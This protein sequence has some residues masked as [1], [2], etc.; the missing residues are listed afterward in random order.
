MEIITIQKFIH[1]SPRKVRLV[2][3]MVRKMEPLKALEVLHFTQKYAARDLSKA[4]E[5]A[6]A[7][8]KQ[9]GLTDGEY[10]FKSLEINE[11]PV[12]KRYRPG[13]KGRAL[14]FKR[15]MS[16]IKIV[17][18]DEIAGKKEVKAEKKKGAKQI[19]ESVK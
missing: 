9:K 5:S 11:G 12:L 13:S 19:T 3:D 15:R 10:R 1:T 14:P 18:S 8:A 6:L 17:L 16:H 2:A 4:I 7:S